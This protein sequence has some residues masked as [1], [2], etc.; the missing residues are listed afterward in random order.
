VISPG[1]ALILH[2]F[3]RAQRQVIALILLP[4]ERLGRDEELLTA[5]QSDDHL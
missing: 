1:L 5:V 2:N 4:Y 3:C